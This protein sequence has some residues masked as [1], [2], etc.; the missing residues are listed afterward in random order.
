MNKLQ[1]LQIQG[2]IGKLYFSH[3]PKCNT[4]IV[5][6][7]NRKTLVCLNCKTKYKVIHPEIDED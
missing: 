5:I 6:A 4:Y 2:K 7:D 3:C 1:I